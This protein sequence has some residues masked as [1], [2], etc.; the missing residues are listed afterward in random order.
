[1]GK[2]PYKNLYTTN[3]EGELIENEVCLDCEHSYI[4]D[5]Y[6]ELC[7]KLNEC[8]KGCVKNDRMDSYCGN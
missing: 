5:I 7:C 3:E 4:D 6:H 8:I 2:E 1:M